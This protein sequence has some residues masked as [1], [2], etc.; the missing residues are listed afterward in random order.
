MKKITLIIITSCFF[1]CKKEDIK[2]DGTGAVIEKSYKWKAPLTEN[3]WIWSADVQVPIFDGK[4]ITATHFEAN[5]KL[6]ALDIYT[7]ETEWEWDDYIGLDVEDVF[8]DM[9]WPYVFD[10]LL[11][12]QKGSRSYCID[13]ST[14]QTK[15]KLQAE[16]SF[17]THLTGKE[18]EYLLTGFEGRDTLGLEVY[19]KL[20]RNIRTGELMDQLPL[21][22]FELFE[23]TA[24][25]G[26]RGVGGVLFE[27]SGKKYFL[28]DYN[29][30]EDHWVATPF[31]SLFNRTDNIWEYTEKQVLPKH[32]TN[33]FTNFPA[34]ED[35]IIVTSIGNYICANDLWTGDSIWT[36]ECG[37]GFLFGGFFIHEGRIYAMAEAEALY[38]FDLHTGSVIWRQDHDG[39]GTTSKMSHLNGVIYFSSGGS[40]TLM[41]VDMATGDIIWNLKTPDG[42]PYKEVAVYP[43]DTDSGPIILTATYQN[44]YC[45]EAVR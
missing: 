29:K 32:R 7:G 18:E 25:I 19:Y 5:A 26:L 41:A 24:N 12:F 28:F 8:L 33:T 31:I 43:G 38:C 17:G 21:P 36:F 22:E 39:L 15:W 13:M 9:M 4:F 16:Q 3:D 23:N 45:F 35:E 1:G 10:N 40:G 2:K 30:Y 11:T 14:G 34:I 20:S 27:D 37:G 6:A 44:A 42:Q